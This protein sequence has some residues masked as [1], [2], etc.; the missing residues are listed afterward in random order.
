M[1]GIITD[2][3]RVSSEFLFRVAAFFYFVRLMRYD[4]NSSCFVWTWAR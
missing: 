1:I 4:M 2:K 3:D